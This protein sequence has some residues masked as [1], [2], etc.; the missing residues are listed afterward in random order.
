MYYI[1]YASTV[2][3]YLIFEEVRDE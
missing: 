1:S 3:N 2:S